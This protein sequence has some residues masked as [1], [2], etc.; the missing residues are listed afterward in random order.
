MRF[1]D[2]PYMKPVMD[3]FTE[4][5]LDGVKS[6][7]IMS[8]SQNINFFNG[9]RLTNMELQIKTRAKEYD[10][11]G[12]G[13][14][15]ITGTVDEMIKRQIEPFRRA[16][17]DDFGNGWK[18]LTNYDAYSMRAFMRQCGTVP[19]GKYDEQVK[20]ALTASLYSMNSHNL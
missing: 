9:R 2:I 6:P 4:L 13:V 11:F 8:T 7:Y 5:E 1:P 17:K 10:P 18:A 16:L 20:F 15:G 12:T 19:H 14:Q 3:L